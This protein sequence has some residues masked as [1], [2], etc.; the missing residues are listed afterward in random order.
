MRNLIIELYSN[1]TTQTLCQVNDR[2][3][4]L[5]EETRINEE[6]V[7]IIE[8]L[9]RQSQDKLGE[10]L[11]LKCDVDNTRETM[12]KM[13]HL[14]RTMKGNLSHVIDR[15][16]FFAAISTYGILAIGDFDDNYA[17]FPYN[18][19]LHGFV[20]FCIFHFVN[21]LSADRGK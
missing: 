11:S 7:K 5:S 8:L 9:L 2:L 14:M 1:D 10:V 4:I 15:Y 3:N 17:Q 18:Y 13:D 21:I 19:L 6:N 12:E 16:F 20:V